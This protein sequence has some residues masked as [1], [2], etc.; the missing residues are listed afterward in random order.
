MRAAALMRADPQRAE[1][2]LVLPPVAVGVLAGLDDRLLGGAI[3]LAPG[4]VIALG[5]AKNLLVTAPGRHAT[6][7]SCHVSTRLTVM[8]QQLLETTDVG[9]VD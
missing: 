5:L 3:D 6:L 8:G 2:A 7:D 9:L 1:L 4:V